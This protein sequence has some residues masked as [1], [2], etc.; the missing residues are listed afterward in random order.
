MHEDTRPTPLGLLRCLQLLTEEADSLGLT[1][2][3]AA[4]HHAIE[5][6]RAESASSVA[7]A[8]PHT[9]PARLH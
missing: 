2:T 9:N 7:L 6:C 4:L 8:F 1:R 5:L 3:F